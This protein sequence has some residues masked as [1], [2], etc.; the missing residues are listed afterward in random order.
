[1]CAACRV[2]V[3]IR[4]MLTVIVLTMTVSKPVGFPLLL[5]FHVFAS[6]LRNARHD[7]RP[8][9]EDPQTPRGWRH[10]HSFEKSVSRKRPALFNIS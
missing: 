10:W 2:R 4:Y 8:G 7:I 5:V 3:L 1:M 6:P 9:A